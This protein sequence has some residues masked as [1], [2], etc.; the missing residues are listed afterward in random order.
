MAIFIDILL[1]T[2]FLFCIIKHARLGLACSVLLATRLVGSL[3]VAGLIY[4]PIARLLHAIGLAEAV[5]GTVAFISVFIA[6]MMLSKLLIE[7]I[8]KIRIPIVTKVDKF[9]GL[10][11]GILLGFIVTSLIS[12]VIYTF[13]DLSSRTSDG[14][15]VSAYYD[16]YIFKFIY[17]LKIFEFIRNLF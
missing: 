17:E 8:S 3:M 14:S 13:I 6:S 5:S 2:V 9:L 1:I 16:S 7:L 12:T 4:Y 15:A 11:L 10:L